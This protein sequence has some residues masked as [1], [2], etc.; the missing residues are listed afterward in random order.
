MDH[1]QTKKLFEN[2]NVF[3]KE[4]EMPK[5]RQG[6]KGLKQ[7]ME[8]LVKLANESFPDLDYI[9]S[10]LREIAEFTKTK[11]SSYRSTFRRERRKLLNTL[12]KTLKTTIPDRGI[13]GKFPSIQ[14]MSAAD[15]RAEYFDA[16]KKGLVDPIRPLSPE[17]EKRE[18]EEA[19]ARGVLSRQMKDEF[20]RKKLGI[21]V[22]PMGVVPQAVGGTYIYL[23]KEIASWDTTDW[24]VNIILLFILPILLEAGIVAPFLEA[25]A[26]RL[27]ASS[28][29]RVALAAMNRIFGTVA[30]RVTSAFGIRIFTW[31]STRGVL[32]SAKAFKFSILI[33]I[34]LVWDLMI[35]ALEKKFRKQFDIPEPPRPGEAEIFM[36][37]IMKQELPQELTDYVKQAIENMTKEEFEE[38]KKGLDK[39]Q[40]KMLN[41]WSKKI[42]NKI[43]AVHQSLLSKDKNYK[44]IV[45]LFA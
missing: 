41:N 13:P 22:G 11:G 9:N 12:S 40:I 28:V 26:T 21:G 18:R 32:L 24:V 23:K 14:P 39:D 29:G 27:A 16:A 36:N 2:W 4:A 31:I 8:E 37:D 17:E 42:E 15:K 25:A 6:V 1:S 20:L 19:R 34:F 43:T 30:A 7:E 45:K 44:T 38:F 35:L 10:K 5:Y 33:G 3:L